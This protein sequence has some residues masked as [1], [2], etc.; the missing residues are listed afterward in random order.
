MG[1]G[2]LQRAQ[3]VGA[4]AATTA[5]ALPV[6]LRLTLGEGPSWDAD[7]R[8]VRVVDIDAGALWAVSLDEERVTEVLRCGTTLGAAATSDDGGF[9]LAAG[10]ALRHVDAAGSTVQE[11]TLVPAAVGSRLNDGA[12]DPHG[13]YVVGSLAT[14]GRRGEE[15][16]WRLE[17]DG[18][19]T[20]LD[21]VLTLSNGLGWSPDGGTF[22]NI[23]SEPG[24][25]W[26][27][28]YDP[29]SGSVGDREVL[30]EIRDGT[31]DGMTVDADGNL[32]VAIWGAG[33][34]RAHSPAGDMIDVV[35]VPAPLSTSCAFV[36]PEL[37]T[38]VV[39]TAHR[40]VPGITPSPEAGRL[41]TAD[42]PV[43]GLPGRMWRP[44]G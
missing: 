5:T 8:L 6:D 22:Y 35:S 2:S 30:I 41:F 24:T 18:T 4:D 28:D 33:E 31:P 43:A 11:I 42:M 34:V 23:D 40:E 10:R 19:V 15:R 38:M 32:W 16:L 44:V 9:L 27:R 37:R 29:S 12:V 25:V 21:D 17:H 14:D 3:S 36:G 39:T 26:R 1:D 20:V 7:Q 13:R